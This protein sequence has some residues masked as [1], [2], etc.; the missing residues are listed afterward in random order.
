MAAKNKMESKK[1]KNKMAATNEPGLSADLS[2]ENYIIYNY[3][4]R[5]GS[6]SNNA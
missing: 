4:V 5:I 2:T 1:Q 6:K 3:C